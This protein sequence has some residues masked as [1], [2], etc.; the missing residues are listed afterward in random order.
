MELLEW[1]NT[2]KY[3]FLDGDIYEGEWN[4]R[5]FKSGKGE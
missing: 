1:K 2:G 4:N 5:E 3:S